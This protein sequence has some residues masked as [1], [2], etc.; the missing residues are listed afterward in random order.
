MERLFRLAAPVLLESVFAARKPQ[1][2]ASA[3]TA[4]A[5]LAGLAI[6]AVTAAAACLLAA[7]W[8]WSLP[9]WGPVGAPLICAAAL[10]IAAAVLAL[11]VAM[12]R[13][14]RPAPPPLAAVAAL[15]P[16]I[17][18]QRLLRDHLGD[19]LLAALLAGLVSGTATRSGGARPR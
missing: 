15:L 19:I 11:A 12:L 10:A 18:G 17:D 4:L 16:D 9:E 8:N 3:A 14:R 1:F 5:G 6:L 2:G 7:L 13:R